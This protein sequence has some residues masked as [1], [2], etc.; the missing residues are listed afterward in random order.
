MK[1]TF[2]HRR[3]LPH[4]PLEDD[5]QE[6]NKV[7]KPTWATTVA[8]CTHCFGVRHCSCDVCHPNKPKTGYVVPAPC[9]TCGASGSRKYEL[10]KKEADAE[11]RNIP[12]SSL[13]PRIDPEWVAYER[14][15]ERELGI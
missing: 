7:S 13:S 4:T 12:W 5:Q 3:H 1:N 10:L 2:S 8:N 6:E 9:K 11:G 15:K 14:K